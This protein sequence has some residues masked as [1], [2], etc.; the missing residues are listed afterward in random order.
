MNSL[1]IGS[2][3]RP[4][5]LSEEQKEFLIVVNKMNELCEDSRIDSDKGALFAITELSQYSKLL[6]DEKFVFYNQARDKQGYLKIW[7][8]V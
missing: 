5:A 8:E 6:G 3:N 2:I 4:K 1:K 7:F